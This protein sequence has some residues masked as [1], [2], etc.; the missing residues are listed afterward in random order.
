M[1]DMSEW[2]DLEEIRG[3]HRKKITACLIGAKT[4]SDKRTGSSY[5]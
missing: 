2:K 3:K 1:L 5:Y 4:R